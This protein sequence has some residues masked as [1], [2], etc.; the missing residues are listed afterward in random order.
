LASLSGV[1]VDGL[2]FEGVDS[3][4]TVGCRS[5]RRPGLWFE[6]KRTGE[7]RD[8]EVVDPARK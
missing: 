6:D 8:G 4:I 3:I 2:P 5:P 7:S 1:S